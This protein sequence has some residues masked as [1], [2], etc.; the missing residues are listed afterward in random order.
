[1]TATGLPCMLCTICRAPTT[2]PAINHHSPGCFTCLCTIVRRWLREVE[3]SGPYLGCKDSPDACGTLPCQR[4]ILYH[5]SCHHDSVDLAIC[6]QQHHSP[7]HAA[8]SEGHSGMLGTLH[9]WILA[10]VHGAGC[11]KTA[12]LAAHL[13][14][15][16]LR[17]LRWF[18]QRTPHH[19]WSLRRWP[20][21]HPAKHAPCQTLHRS[22]HS[23]PGPSSA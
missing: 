3:Q 13:Q 10:V 11:M 5:P 18:L 21:S 20:P 12:S 23:C 16:I 22:A 17:R 2:C 6:K 8:S 7:L 9:T 15:P 4:G 19:T 14:C 1:M